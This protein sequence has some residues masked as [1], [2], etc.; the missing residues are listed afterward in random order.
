MNAVHA[1]PPIPG[2]RAP[3][4]R[5]RRRRLLAWLAAG[6]L[7]AGPGLAQETQQEERLPTGK[8]TTEQA[9][10]LLTTGRAAY[11]D[12]LYRLARQ[13]LQDLIAG[14]P[15]R[16][17][18]AEGA[19][20]LAR[21][22]L[23][24]N[25]PQ[26]A[27]ALLDSY[28]GQVR[29]A[30]LA[31]D[32]ALARA[33]AQFA[34]R[35]IPETAAELAV[36]KEKFADESAAPSALFLLAQVQA[37]Q[38]EWDAAR[39]TCALIESRHAGNPAGA[40]AWLEVASA[41][42]A[43]GRLD[44]AQAALAHV[45]QTWTGQVWSERAILQGIE[46]QMSQGRPDVALERLE[47]LV[48]N[49]NLL[50]ET[51]ATGYR[52]T[53]AALAAGTNYTA[54]L[55]MIERGIA[56]ATHPAQKLEGE[57]L[58]ADLL[59]RSGRVNEGATLMRSV[60]AR[61]PDRSQAAR[62][63]QQLASR[64]GY[65]DKWN[66]AA[67]EYQAW[68][69][70]FDGAEGTADILAALAWSLWSAGRPGEA[71]PVFERAAAAEP[72]PARRLPLLQKTADSHFASGQFTKAKTAYAAVLSAAPAGGEMAARAQIQLAE[73]ELAMG[74]TEAGEIRL[75]DLSRAK[76]ETEFSRTA[77]MRLGAL[78]EER[79]ALET[80]MEQYG[81]LIESCLEPQTCAQAL[82]ARGLI[83]YRMGSFQA[84]LDD[85]LRIRDRFPQ[86]RPAAQ[87]MFMRGW[88]LYLLGK[89]AEALEVC[90]QFLADYPGSE[91][92]PD[93]QFWLGEYAF[94]HGDYATAEERFCRVAADHPDSPRAPD[95]LY[96]AGR[97]A[98]ARRAYLAANEHYN[99]LM[100]R[101]PDQPRLAET[102]LAQGDVLSEL[103][104][105]GAAILAFNEVIVNFPQQPQAMVAWGRKGDCQ[106][107]LGQEN[108]ARY[109]EALL[110]YRTLLD[111]AGAPV[112]LRLQAGFKIGRCLE[113]MGR[114]A[115]ALDR[116]MEVVYAY[117]QETDSP[118]EGT[119]WFT[120]AAFGA[121]ALQERAGKW[122]EAFGIYRRV[123]DSSLPAAAEARDRMTRI[124][125]EHWHLF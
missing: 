25:N 22:L 120:R 104:Q 73:S 74:E 83:R 49:T 15:D 29:A 88:C 19:L 76:T 93:V 52:M 6:L 65:L 113:Q 69:D 41:L 11:E 51:R 121:A 72:E 116:Y 66:E 117:L 87:A 85:F 125:Q 43:T 45:E 90:T 96:W 30:V 64:L 17:R 7:A 75:L 118:P 89:D 114:T 84:A 39:E 94:N 35:Q 109:E 31:A 105:F 59:L 115:A 24:E 37:A 81:R 58:Q 111:F 95:A 32:V 61:M 99:A 98:T 97:T 21:V 42:A 28:G 18:Q 14:A 12:G 23:A 4:L 16:R 38:G 80:A 54:A 10:R 108:P 92:A 123:A 112:D 57:R 2:D 40:D 55:D 44:E 91:F 62:I 68:L 9:G 48:A 103:G 13:R 46:L 100:T 26:E 107:T 1:C 78:Y 79:G 86:T 110:S 34:L 119:V 82:L 101:Y 56:A 50:P 36:F 124:R 70:A 53:A 77:T 71:A 67:A 5:S 3:A 20:W 122:K 27:L 47:A 8:L 106:Y 63:Q 60:A 33:Q 102:L